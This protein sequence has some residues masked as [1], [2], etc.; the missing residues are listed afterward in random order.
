MGLDDR[1]L[2]SESCPR[3]TLESTNRPISSRWLA[4]LIPGFL[5]SP[6]RITTAPRFRATIPNRARDWLPWSGSGTYRQSVK[7]SW[8]KGGEPRVHYTR[9]DL[10]QL[11]DCPRTTELPLSMSA[12]ASSHIYLPI[13]MTDVSP[14]WTHL[15]ELTRYHNPFP[16]SPCFS[17]VQPA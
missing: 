10:R 11:M 7:D 8:L 9:R 13:Y 2:I 1:H 14:F 15:P 16:S 3:H 6:P 17:R 12:P 5:R 4:L